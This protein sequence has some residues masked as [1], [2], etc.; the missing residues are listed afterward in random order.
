MVSVSSPGLFGCRVTG[1]SGDS[2][3]PEGG[4]QLDEQGLEDQLRRSRPSRSR[5]ASRNRSTIRN[6]RLCSLPRR[7]F[8]TT[9][10]RNRE[11]CRIQQRA[12][13]QSRAQPR[14][15]PVETHRQALPI[16]SADVRVTS[17]RPDSRSSS[18]PSSATRGLQ[19][20]AQAR[21]RA[22]A[23]HP[24]DRAGPRRHGTSSLPSHC[25]AGAAPGRGISTRW[26][27]LRSV[28]SSRKDARSP[29]PARSGE[30]S[31]ASSTAHSGRS[32][33][34]HARRHDRHR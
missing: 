11:A 19:N 4:H 32:W 22:V 8:A 1:P 17:L 6:A 12:A 30:G 7:P 2:F 31:R 9:A 34:S 24:P 25:V 28:A 23:H 10:A 33:S 27:R 21:P 3:A 20:G 18:R 29:A 15:Q 26:Q 14:L 16:I 5:R 13:A